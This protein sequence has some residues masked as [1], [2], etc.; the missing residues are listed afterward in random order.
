MEEDVDVIV[1]ERSIFIK[2]AERLWNCE[3]W[4]L[5]TPLLFPVNIGFRESG[6]E[7]RFMCDSRFLL[8][9]IPDRFMNVEKWPDFPL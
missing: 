8:S 3:G 6:M 7:H 5:T 9:T 1:Q 2:E 4:R